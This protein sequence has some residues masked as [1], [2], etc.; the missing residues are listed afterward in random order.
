MILGVW[1][2][3]L[4][5]TGVNVYHRSVAYVIITKRLWTTEKIQ[6]YKSFS[7]KCILLYYLE[8]LVRKVLQECINCPFAF[9]RKIHLPL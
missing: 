2:L 3:T 6:N 7:C 4:R 1:D 8:P 9:I 5:I